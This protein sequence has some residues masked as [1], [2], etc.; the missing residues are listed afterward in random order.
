MSWEDK[1]KSWLDGEIQTY[2]SDKINK[3]FFYETSPITKNMK[4]KYQGVFIKSDA[5][6][7]MKEDYSSFSQNIK[8]SENS[9]VTSFYNL[10]K[11]AYL[12]IPIPRKSKQFTTLK[13]FMDNASERQQRNL[14]KEVA[15]SIIMMLKKYDKVWVSTHGLGVPYLHI[16]IDTNPKYY[17]TVKFKNL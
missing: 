6:D 3:R 4:E 10:S 16:R 13:D 5:L 8:K 12:V 14:W 15:Q 17:Q 2:P 9:D 7:K 1:I 11:S